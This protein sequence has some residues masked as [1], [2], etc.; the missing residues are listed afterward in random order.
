MGCEYCFF[1]NNCFTLFIEIIFGNEEGG[2]NYAKQ[3]LYKTYI[4]NLTLIIRPYKCNISSCGK[5]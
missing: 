2:I 1:L 3:L 4:T 5:Q